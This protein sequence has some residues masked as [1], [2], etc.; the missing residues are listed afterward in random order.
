MEQQSHEAVLYEKMGAHVALVTINRPEARNAVNGAVAEAIEGIVKSVEADGDIRAVVLTGS[1]GKVFSAG[2]DLKEV[3]AGNLNK[4]IR[5]ETGFAGFVFHERTKPWIA[6]VEGLALA[7]GCELA[8][9][10]DMIVASEGGAFGLPEV[11]RGLIASAG[12]LFR[13]PRALPRAIAIEM[14]LT[15]DRLPSERA[16]ELGMVNHLAPAGEV[17]AAA[18]A[19]AEKIASNA[20]VAVAESLKLAKLSADLEDGEL[21]RLSQEAQD[22][23]MLTEDFQEGPLAFIE[24]R[25][26]VWKGR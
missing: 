13:L 15:A 7:G 26:P 5:P 14:I 23:I 2:A 21:Q 18:L 12:G 1:G 6:A 19:I 9:A 25:A 20:P 22:R 17:V 16:A 8:L 4:L 10:C 11:L 3:S 24:K